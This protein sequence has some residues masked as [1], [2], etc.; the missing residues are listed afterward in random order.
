MGYSP[1]ARRV[2]AAADELRDALAAYGAMGMLDYGQGLET[3]P[4]ALEQTS[5]GVQAMAVDALQT[6][7]LSPAVVQFLLDLSQ[8]IMWLA[9]KAYE[10]RTVFQQAHEADIL[11]LSGGRPNEWQW[12]AGANR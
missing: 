4:Y 9:A 11:R 3:I 5:R 10:V 1:E 6:R 2:M 7:P 12:D 8:A